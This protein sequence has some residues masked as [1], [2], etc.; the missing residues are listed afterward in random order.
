MHPMTTQETMMT[1]ALNATTLTYNGN[2]WMLQND[3]GNTRIQDAVTGSIMGLHPGFIPLGMKERGGV[4]YIA[5]VKKDD[6]G[7]LIGELGSIPSPYI[8]YSGQEDPYVGGASEEERVEITEEL[9]SKQAAGE[10]TKEEEKYLSPGDP[11]VVC[12]DIDADSLKLIS[13]TTKKKWYKIKLYAVTA[14]YGE[15]D[16]TSMLNLEQYQQQLTVDDE[17]QRDSNYW[18]ATEDIQNKLT[19]LAELKA[20][21][22]YPNVPD[23]KLCIKVEQEGITNFNFGPTNILQNHVSVYCPVVFSQDGHALVQ[24]QSF[25]YDSD[26]AWQIKKLKLTATASKTKSWDAADEAVIVRAANSDTFINGIQQEEFFTDANDLY[27][28]TLG[29]AIDQIIDYGDQQQTDDNTI[30]CQKIFL[31]QDD[32]SKA[33]IWKR[34]VDFKKFLIINRNNENQFALICRAKDLD[35]VND[36]EN[37]YQQFNNKCCHD[38]IYTLDLN[39]DLNQWIKIKIDAYDTINGTDILIK[40]GR[41]ELLMNP[42]LSYSS[43]G[44]NFTIAGETYLSTGDNKIQGYVNQFVD[45]TVKSDETFF[46]KINGLCRPND[47]QFYSK[48]DEVAKSYI[49]IESADQAEYKIIGEG[50]SAKE[51]PRIEVHPQFKVNSNAPDSESSA[52]NRG[53][54]LGYKENDKIWNYFYYTFCALKRRPNVVKSYDPAAPSRNRQFSYAPYLTDYNYQKF[55]CEK[56]GAKLNKFCATQANYWEGWDAN[57]DVYKDGTTKTVITDRSHHKD[58]KCP[59]TDS[60]GNLQYVTIHPND[61]QD[62]IRSGVLRTDIDLLATPRA[63]NLYDKIVDLEF[64]RNSNVA[65]NKQNYDPSFHEGAPF[66]MPSEWESATAV[67]NKK[68][69]YY[70]DGERGAMSGIDGYPSGDHFINFARNSAGAWYAYMSEPETRGAGDDFHIMLA[71]KFNNRNLLG[72]V[73]TAIAG[74]LAREKPKAGTPYQL[75]LNTHYAPIVYKY[76]LNYLLSKDD[77]FSLKINNNADLG[78]ETQLLVYAHKRRLDNSF[79]KAALYCNQFVN[80]QQ[81]LF[82]DATPEKLKLG[83]SNAESIK[84]YR[85]GSSNDFELRHIMPTGS[86]IQSLSNNYLLASGATMTL[87][88]DLSKNAQTIDWTHLGL[89][90][91]E[92]DDSLVVKWQIAG[93][94]IAIALIT[95]AAA[96]T[97]AVSELSATAVSILAGGGVTAGSLI[98]STAALAGC[99]ALAAVSMAAAIGEIIAVGFMAADLAKGLSNYDSIIEFG[100]KA[101]EVGVIDYKT[102][103]QL[104]SAANLGLAVNSV[105]TTSEYDAGIEA[106]TPECETDQTTRVGLLKQELDPS[107]TCGYQQ[108]PSSSNS[109]R[110]Y[111]IGLGLNALLEVDLSNSEID[112]KNQSKYLLRPQMSYV[113]NSGQP[114]GFR[115]EAPSTIDI[116]LDTNYLIEGEK[117]TDIFSETIFGKAAGLVQVDAFPDSSFKQYGWLTPDDISLDGKTITLKKGHY[118]INCNS[119]Q[120]KKDLVTTNDNTVIVTQPTSTS[121]TANSISSLLSSSTGAGPVGWRTPNIE[122]LNQITNSV[123]STISL[124]SLFSRTSANAY[125]TACIEEKDSE[126]NKAESDFTISFIN[127][128]QHLYLAHD[129]TLMNFV[130]P[131]DKRKVYYSMGIYKVNEDDPSLIS[132]FSIDNPNKSFC[133]QN[134]LDLISTPT[135]FCYEENNGFMDKKYIGRWFPERNYQ[136]C[137][138]LYTMNSNMISGDGDGVG[139]GTIE[140]NAATIRTIYS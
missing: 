106:T 35:S 56:D 119:F 47:A 13:T 121:S 129:V 20:C 78:A 15:I 6:N 55:I 64:Y 2:E 53:L 84:M 54:L 51:L 105:Y 68:N 76:A 91:F 67:D 34:I 111:F 86:Y 62:G 12:L 85:L 102:L 81:T 88:I 28:A 138:K 1:D 25:I 109:S 19:R 9:Q 57:S 73:T 126:G 112:Y 58:S 98:T 40:G 97:V 100:N 117:I 33:Q 31:N 61:I 27:T 70:H 74:D 90:D 125:C 128:R 14:E 23:G 116:D 49:S 5:S 21:L 79:Y 18:F 95:A 45:K 130:I 77:K 89:V 75:Y 4:L 42:S 122:E 16:L 71:S 99:A 136:Y 41:L 46:L 124:P 135:V 113:T 108:E 80:G 93:I 103:G 94:A 123:E 63:N 92:Y 39:G 7:K 115:G 137:K 11:F 96:G 3:M 107:G 139:T 104:T 65:G 29:N 82:T 114:A 10:V 110:K 50:D 134:D 37:Y 48:Y 38:A 43:W 26:S 69:Y 72:Q 8:T 59:I 120:S 66:A 127:G 87:P 44:T 101:V 30:V 32:E 131:G 17:I 133:N 52:I 140:G 36:S 118:I 60:N 22:F 83:D 132:S 24:M